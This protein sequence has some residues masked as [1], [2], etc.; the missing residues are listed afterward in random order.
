[1]TSTDVETHLPTTTKS[2][3]SPHPPPPPPSSSTS[4]STIHI[5][6]RRS[7]LALL[8]ADIVHTALQKAW[9]HQRFEIHAMSTMGDKNQT[10]P[11]HDF[12]AKSLWTHEL[13]AGL[14]D[15]SLDLI[16][17]SLKGLSPPPPPLSV[18]Q[19]FHPAPT[20]R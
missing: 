5:G 13:E 1:M 8:Q 18:P 16:V 9:P 19:F 3:P 4:T 11:L 15:G 12:G 6:T 10:T 17:H 14:V 2:N 20:A 7:K